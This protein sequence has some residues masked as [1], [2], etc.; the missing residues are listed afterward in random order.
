MW[1]RL[2]LRSVIVVEPAASIPAISTHDLTWALATGTSYSMPASS[3][4]STL[5]GGRRSSRAWQSAPIILQRLDHPVH[6]PA[7]DR[8][9]A[10]ER[11]YAARLAGEPARQQ[12]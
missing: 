2:C 1:S 8:L 5:S 10:V 6:R 7:A 4:P 9:V 3:V 12:A 11:P